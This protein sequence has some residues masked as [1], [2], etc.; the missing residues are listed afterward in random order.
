[1][2]PSKLACLIRKPFCWYNQLTMAAK[3]DV[4]STII[5]TFSTLVMAVFTIALWW[6]SAEQLGQIKAQTKAMQDQLTEMKEGSEDTKT[7]SESTKAQAESTRVMA[8][9][10]LRDQRAWVGP[11]RVANPRVTA[12]KPVGLEIDYVNGGRSPARSFKVTTALKYQP[13]SEKFVPD[14]RVL[15]TSQA[16]VAMYPQMI[17]SSDLSQINFVLEKKQID[18]LING[19]FRM[20]VF[21]KYTY[22]TV[23]VEGGGTFCIFFRSEL[24]QAPGWCDSYND[25][26]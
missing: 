3:I 6:T 16:L 17:V 10:M 2:L 11:Y 1:M 25:I 15:T 8:E 14:Y 20:Y 5:V 12:G 13:S 4:S 22:S 26:Y 19:S 24:T 23:N 7:I 21:G 9:S 18:Q